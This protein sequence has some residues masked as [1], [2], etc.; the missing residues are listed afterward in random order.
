MAQ[1]S[2]MA[3]VDDTTGQRS[4]GVK[5]KIIHMCGAHDWVIFATI[6]PLFTKNIWGRCYDHNFLR[7]KWRFSQKP[8]L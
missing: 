6:G 7:K 4:R 1:I 8:M 5:A 3:G 2:S